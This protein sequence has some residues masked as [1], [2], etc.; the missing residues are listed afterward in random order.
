MTQDPRLLSIAD[1]QYDLPPEKIAETPLPV[2][3]ESKLLC[4][5]NGIIGDY[6]YLELASL[7]PSNSFLVFNET[8]VIPARLLFE[9]D[10][11]GTIEIFCLQPGSAQRDMCEALQLTTQAT[12]QCLVGGASKWKPGVPLIKEVGELR[13]QASVRQKE[14]DHFL[15][16]LSW[17]PQELTLSSVFELAGATP[18][19]PYIKRPLSK[20]DSAAYQ[21]VY[22]KKE[23]SVA[24][25]TAGLHF[26]EELLSRLQDNKIES[27]F[28]TLHVGAGTFKPVKAA[29][30]QDHAM[31]AEWI[32][33]KLSFLKNWQRQLDHPLVA[34][35]TT[36]LRTL[37][38]LYWLGLKLMKEDHAA[39]P[40]LSQWEWYTLQKETVPLKKVLSTLI[41]WMEDKKLDQFVTQTSLLITP[42][43]PFQVVNALLTNFHQPRST[44]LLL[45]A[46]LVKEDWRKIYQHAL[47][48][49]YRFLSF[50]DGS[51]LWRNDQ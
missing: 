47:D 41:A 22:A 39:P 48:S 11:G 18:L 32:D 3:H 14:H 17:T 24:A 6:Q 8:K 37:E 49:Q 42:G 2:R 30:M 21:T 25:P 51:L 19:P 34:V 28:L 33:V 23:G 20:N 50:G 31:H 40:P 10:T 26:T 35:G 15:I 12:L 43:Y 36:S 9:K 46:A 29:I 5:Q 4:Y 44:L 16:D 27:D 45:I 1:Y 38:S 7:L 13:L